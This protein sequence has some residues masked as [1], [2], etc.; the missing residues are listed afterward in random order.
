[1]SFRPH[2]IEIDGGILHERYRL[3]DSGRHAD[4]VGGDY[5]FFVDLIEEDGGRVGL[6]SGVHY[7]MAIREAGAAR[8][9]FE[10]S[11]PVRDLIGGAT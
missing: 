3:D 8:I 10:I 2:A 7:S 1:M 6:R 11:E 9:E 4:H 5:R